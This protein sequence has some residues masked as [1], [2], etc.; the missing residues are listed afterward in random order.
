MKNIYIVNAYRWGDR[1][2]HSYTLGVFDKKELAI[3]CADSHT[4]YRGGKYGC[5]VEMCLLNEFDNDKNNYTVEVY[6][7]KSCLEQ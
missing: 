3:E 5:A 1:E 2:N 7:T 6:R 4:N